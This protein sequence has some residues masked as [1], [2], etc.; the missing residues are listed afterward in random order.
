VLDLSVRDVVG[1]LGRDRT[2]LDH[3][4]ADVGQKLLAQ[5][6]GKPLTPH[7]R[8]IDIHATALAGSR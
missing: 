7:S 5:A 8:K 2:G 3:H 6:L 1:Q 4:H